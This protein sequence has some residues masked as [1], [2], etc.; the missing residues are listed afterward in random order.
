VKND[1]R[2]SRGLDRAWDL[3]E[4]GEMEEAIRVAEGLKAR[5]PEAPEI[6]LLLAACARAQGKDDEALGFLKAAIDLDPEWAEPELHA[7]EL[8]AESDDLEAALAHGRRA[9]AK[10][11][12]QM[13]QTSATALVAGLELDQELIDEA[14]ATLRTLPRAAEAD[15]SAEVAREIGDLHLALDDASQAQEWFERAVTLDDQD[16][17]AW[18]GIGLAAELAREE[19]AK[20]RAWLKTLALDEEQDR[21]LPELLSEKQTAEVAEAA[22]AELPPRARRLLANVPILIADRPARSDVATGL[23]PRLLGLFAGTSYP[24]F[25]SLGATP[26]LTQILLFRRNLERVAFDEEELKAEIRT[27]L[28]HETGHFFGMSEDDLHQVGLG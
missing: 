6:P 16:A 7:A 5:S 1:S 2:L 27:T 20:R 9:L 17:D 21:D 8:L 24:E 4:A 18:H 13:E 19:E 10:A 26:Q 12:D 25:S 22:L 14:S 28:L 23:D 15:T 3:L 11:A